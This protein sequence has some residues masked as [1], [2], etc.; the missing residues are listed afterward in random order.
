MTEGELNH[1]FKSKV[2]AIFLE[3]RT[4]RAAELVLKEF[5]SLL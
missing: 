1:I 3:I 5:L 4:R 2:E